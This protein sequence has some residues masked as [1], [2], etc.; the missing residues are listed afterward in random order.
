MKVFIVL[1]AIAAIASA[2]F[3]VKHFE[4]L[5]KYHDECG[6][7]NKVAAEHITKF[8][9][10]EY[11]ADE[12]SFC[13]VRCLSMKI[14][15]FDDEHGL[16]EDNMV[17]QVAAANNKPVDEVRTVVKECK[18]MVDEFKSNHCMWAFK[19]FLCLKKHGFNVTDRKSA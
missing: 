1:L 15:V 19:G 14:G 2:E 8:K 4:D 7:E 6:A 5:L 18:T 11:G 16:L 9:N 12:E 13:H 17:T 10:Q 3:T